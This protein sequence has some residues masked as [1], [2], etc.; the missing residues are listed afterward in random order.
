MILIW[1][2]KRLKTLDSKVLSLKV[3]SFYYRQEILYCTENTEK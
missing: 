3:S 2:G 1:K